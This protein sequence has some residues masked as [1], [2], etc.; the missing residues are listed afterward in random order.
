VSR[1]RRLW[2]AL[3]DRIEGPISEAD[4]KKIERWVGERR[5]RDANLTFTPE[6]EADIRP[7]N[8]HKGRHAQ[9]SDFPK[10]TTKDD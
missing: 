8:R 4:K 5:E 7:T 3:W 10:Q 9:P 6:A 1:L 2:E